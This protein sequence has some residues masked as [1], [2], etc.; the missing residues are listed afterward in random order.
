MDF[1][2][3][4]NL[5]AASNTGTSAQ[6]SGGLSIIPLILMVAIFG[7]MY[8]LMIRPQKKKQKKEEAMRNNV[9]I[10]DEIIT[11]GGFYGRVAALKDDNSIIIE[12]VVDHTKQKIVK[13]AIQTN[14]TVHDDQ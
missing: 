5:L 14:L 6:E 11:I 9:Q 1:S 12:S 10:G 13:S 3:S 4:L 7:V 8:L 2:N